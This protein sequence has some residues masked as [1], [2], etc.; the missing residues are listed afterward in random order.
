MQSALK[1]G[2]QTRFKDLENNILYAENTILDPRFKARALKNLDYRERGIEGLKN[3]VGKTPLQAIQNNDQEIL[4]STTAIVPVS[5]TD[6]NGN[7]KSCMSIWD[8]YDSEVSKI[9]KPEN[10]TVAV[11]REVDKYLNEKY[12]DRKKHPLL[13]WHERRFIYPHLYGNILKR[14]CIVATSVPCE[15]VFSGAGQMIS[16]RR[17]LLKPNRVSTL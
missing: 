6:E 12:L 8:E 11:I 1:R 3:K 15:R 16:Q 17:K 13:W 7:K 4:S 14:F 9:T 5:V 10:K 2:M